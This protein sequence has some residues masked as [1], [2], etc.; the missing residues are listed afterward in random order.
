[1]KKFSI[2][3]SVMML[4]FAI[5]SR[6]WA[7]TLEIRTD[8]DISLAS[9]CPN[10]N[11]NNRSFPYLWVGDDTGNRDY[12]AMF[13]F[14]M[15]P[16]TNMLNP[17]D[18]LI[19]NRLIFSAYNNYNYNY[20]AGSVKIALG[21]DDNWSDS[22]AT[23]SNL[24]N[25]HGASLDSVLVG[26]NTLYHYVEW[27]VTAGI[28]PD[29]FLSDNYLTFYLFIT[30]PGCGNNWHD[31]EMEEWSGSNEARLFIDYDIQHSA[32]VPEP[33]TILLLGVGLIGLAGY[34]RKRL[35]EKA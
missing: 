8:Q 20:L 6:T 13:G 18:A 23:Y 29:D 4:V 27:D 1:M 25:K 32:P 35:V 21:T 9:D 15:S 30:N 12:Q 33:S 17:G 24:A 11:Y 34:G 22:T 26:P 28:S 14:D 31:F 16:L 5:A 10:C 7:M 19:L 3:L 2:F